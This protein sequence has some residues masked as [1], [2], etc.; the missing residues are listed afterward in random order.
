MER[1][2]HG[3]T[4]P[5]AQRCHI[6]RGEETLATTRH[7]AVA[8]G[9]QDPRRVVRRQVGPAA[10]VKGVRLGDAPR[11]L[12]LRDGVLGAKRVLRRQEVEALREEAARALLA[13]LVKAELAARLVAYSQLFC[14]HLSCSQPNAARLA[15]PVVER[16]VQAAHRR[17]RR[18]R[19]R[20]I[21]N[22][23]A[24]V[25]LRALIRGDLGAVGQALCTDTRRVTHCDPMTI[26]VSRAVGQ[27][28]G[29]DAAPDARLVTAALE[30]AGEDGGA[31]CV[32]LA[33]R[34]LARA[35][36]EG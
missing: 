35:F 10:A 31:L 36:P 12:R 34:H 9:V 1:P 7:V 4:S 21:V 15:A 13:R 5:N 20:R 19:R 16:L 24:P 26:K 3:S 25:C 30:S 27:T 2:C 11:D 29:R 33:A 8:V 14:S 23:Q 6:K 17:L 28:P 22:R 18:L 32:L